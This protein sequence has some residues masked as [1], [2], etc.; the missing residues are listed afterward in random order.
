M[1]RS[2]GREAAGLDPL[3]GLR[4]VNGA[5]PGKLRD[6]LGAEIQDLPG[7]TKQNTAFMHHKAKISQQIQHQ[8]FFPPVPQKHPAVGKPLSRWNGLLALPDS[9]GKHHG[10]PVVEF[11]AGFHVAVDQIQI[12]YGLQRL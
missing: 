4:G 3:E 5:V 10:F 2:L 7:T 6:A 12:G 8:R 9:E 11:H 1:E